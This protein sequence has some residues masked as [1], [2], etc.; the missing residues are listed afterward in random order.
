M[1]SAICKVKW[2]EIS[3]KIRQWWHKRSAEQLIRI[4]RKRNQS[5]EIL[6]KRY[7]YSQEQAASEFKKH[8]ST[9]ARLD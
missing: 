4:N 7:G 9:T 5:I 2:I 6:Q 8:Y 1:T 3:D